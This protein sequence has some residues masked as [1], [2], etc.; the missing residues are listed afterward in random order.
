MYAVMFIFQISRKVFRKASVLSANRIEKSFV[1]QKY[2]VAQHY[3]KRPLLV[4][5]KLHIPVLGEVE[6]LLEETDA[7]SFTY[8]LLDCLCTKFKIG[9]SG[10]F[11][12]KTECD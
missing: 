3:T 6:E 1:R 11:V 12:A 5:T 8:Q 7:F 9:F 2:C 10:I 4:E